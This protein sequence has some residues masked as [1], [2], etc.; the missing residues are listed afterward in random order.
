VPS[1]RASRKVSGQLTLTLEEIRQKERTIYSH[2]EDETTTDKLKRGIQNKLVE[3]KA[4]HKIEES[5]S[6]PTMA[7]EVNVR[8]GQLQVKH[9]YSK[10]RPVEAL[11][12]QQRFL[13]ASHSEELCEKW[14]CI[15]NWV[16]EKDLHSI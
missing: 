11:Y 2:V 3:E 16:I 14:I 10:Q 5:L 9:F 1:S 7:S 4:K 15:L 8:Q 12:P 13:F 6:V